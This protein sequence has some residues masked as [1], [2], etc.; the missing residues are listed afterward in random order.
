VLH[1]A[2]LEVARLESRRRRSISY[3]RYVDDMIILC[4]DKE[5]CEEA[6]ATYRGVVTGLKLPIHDPKPLPPHT[7]KDAR[8]DFYTQKSNDPYL[9]HNPTLGGHP[10]IQFV[11]YQIRHDGLVRIRLRSV[12][13]ELTKLRTTT[14]DLIQ[15]LSSPGKTP[16]RCSAKQILY[17]FRMKLISMSVGRASLGYTVSPELPMC[18]AH[19]FRGLRHCAFVDSALKEL[20]RY[21][22]RQIGRLKARL[23]TLSLPEKSEAPNDTHRVLPFYGRPF[24]Y[25]GQ[26]RR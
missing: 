11:G 7:D 22:E 1:Q 17:R 9:W 2:D 24:S 23:K 13:K 10:W 14:D 4:R 8:V 26:F 6:F 15:R 3:L 5:L 19:G 20:D 25:W 18:W 16:I 12:K 21:R